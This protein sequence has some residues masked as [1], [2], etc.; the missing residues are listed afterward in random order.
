[1][2]FLASIVIIGVA[3]YLRVRLKE[4][5]T[6]RKLEAHDQIAERPL[7]ELLRSARPTL[8]RGIG[9]RLAENGSSSM[10]QALAIA[11]VTSAAV[12]I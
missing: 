2:P 1:M 3:F 4:S 12:G 7:Y 11:Y 10:Y 8:W 5:P 9:F 6:F